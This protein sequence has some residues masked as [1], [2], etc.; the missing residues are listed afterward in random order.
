MRWFTAWDR[1]NARLTY[2]V[3]RSGGQARQLD[4]ITTES[5]FWAPVE[6]SVDDTEVETGSYTYRVRVTDPFGNRRLSDP[7][8]VD[9][10]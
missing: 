4:P 3:L 5:S 7:V 10:P 8:Q 1:D 6:L 2:E 9:V